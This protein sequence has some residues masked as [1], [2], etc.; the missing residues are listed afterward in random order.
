MGD[1]KEGPSPPTWKLMIVKWLGIFPP[2]L[3]IA[4]GLSLVS[5]QFFP[6]E[7]SLVKPDGTLVLWF[8]LLCETL[9]LVPLLNLVITPWLDDV[10]EGWLYAGIPEA[11]R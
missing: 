9:I 4:Y 5:K 2:L 11:E 8:K 3:L 6:T 1:P 7:W 10:F